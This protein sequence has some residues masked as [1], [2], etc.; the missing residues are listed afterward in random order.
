MDSFQPILIHNDGDNK[1]K[2]SQNE[3]ESSSIQAMPSSSSLSPPPTIIRST[4]T[5]KTSQQQHNNMTFSNNIMMDHR[6]TTT[7]HQHRSPNNNKQRT[8][9]SSRN[10]TASKNKKNNKNYNDNNNNKRRTPRV[11]KELF[12]GIFIYVICITAPIIFGIILKWYEHFFVSYTNNNGDGID[13]YDNDKNNNMITTLLFQ[14]LNNH[15]HLHKIL[16]KS[17]S[18]LS[19]Y[20]YDVQFI[21]IATI[22]Q[23]IVRVVLVHLLVPRYLAPRRLIAFVRNKSTHLLSSSSYEWNVNNN[24]NDHSQTKGGTKLSKKDSFIMYIQ[25]KIDHTTHS[26]HRSLG[27]DTKEGLS[28]LRKDKLYSQQQQEQQ[29]LLPPLPNL[30]QLDSSETLRLFAAPR[31]ATAIFRLICCTISCTYALMNFRKASYWP[32]WVGGSI[33]GKT[34]YCWDLAGTV[35]PSFVWTRG[36]G[37]NKNYNQN[38]ERRMVNDILSNDSF[39]SD[40]DNQNSAL[41]YF[42]LGQA[43]YQL[44]SLCFHFLSMILLLIYSGM[45]K[46]KKSSRNHN[47]SGGSS[48]NDSSHKSRIVSARSSIKS[49]LRPV[50]EHSIYFVLTISTFFFSALR[51]LGSITIFALEVSS[52]ILQILQICINAPDSSPLHKPNVIQFVHHYMA[53]PFFIYCRLIVI[54]FVVMYSVAF[55]SSVWLKQI[56]HAFLPGCGM[57]IYYIFNG[58]LGLALILNFIYLRRL[59]FHPCLQTIS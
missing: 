55:E 32:I 13:Y 47:E 12:Q 23:S 46:R 15:Q 45:K 49:Y 58:T 48:L 5:K 37:D 1:H 22:L 57:L 25:D 40:F 54:P 6:T 19:S 11:M 7:N 52:L 42:F 8:R 56:D 4:T 26:L 18:I 44:Q 51:R 41:R 30:D 16:I 36:G 43:S 34:K 29:N 59:I 39:D 14:F 2:S 53:I 3:K 24:N 10:A 27:H 31:Y 17:S 33:H 9:S 21:I 50:V 28:P 38:E 20:S 35:D